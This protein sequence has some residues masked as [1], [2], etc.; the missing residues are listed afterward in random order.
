M[1]FKYDFWNV[2]LGFWLTGVE[3]AR[4]REQVR[5]ELQSL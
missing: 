4:I 3:Q 1:I 2:T 5:D